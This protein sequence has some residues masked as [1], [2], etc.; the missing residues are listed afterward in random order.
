MNLKRNIG[1]MV[2]FTIVMFGV[3]A[4]IYPTP[5]PAQDFLIDSLDPLSNQ[6]K[7]FAGLFVCAYLI[8]CLFKRCLDGIKRSIFLGFSFSIIN[9]SGL[10][11]PDLSLI[12]YFLFEAIAGTF[13]LII[14]VMM[15]GSI[16]KNTVSTVA[17]SPSS[18]TPEASSLE[19]TD[20]FL[21]RQRDSSA[22]DADKSIPIQSERASE[23]LQSD[24]APSDKPKPGKKKAI[25]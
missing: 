17:D 6:L 19:T 16:Y 2:F 3:L 5:A 13:N 4:V 22:A 11:V 10:L 7:Y 24:P 12:N 8:L 23:S 9:F 25:H 18:N 1:S 15:A 20:E 21:E 14:C